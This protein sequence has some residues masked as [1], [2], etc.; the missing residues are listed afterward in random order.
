M[1]NESLTATMPSG[2]LSRL[3]QDGVGI[4]GKLVVGRGHRMQRAF[5]CRHHVPGED[6]QL[7]RSVTVIQHSLKEA[8]ARNVRLVHAKHPSFVK[9]EG[10]SKPV[11]SVAAFFG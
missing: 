11:A 5:C 6:A 2:F 3:H 9:V 4:V 1:E 7:L 8:L 10:F